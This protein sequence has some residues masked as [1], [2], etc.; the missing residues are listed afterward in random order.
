MFSSLVKQNKKAKNLLR[1]SHRRRKKIIILYLRCD[2]EAIFYKLSSN[3]YLCARVCVLAFVCVC[4]YVRVR[5]R[6]CVCA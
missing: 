3:Y 4:M 2:C 5:V 1:N 6:V